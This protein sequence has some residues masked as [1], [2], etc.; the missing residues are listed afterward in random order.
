LWP[1]ALNAQ[2]C[3]NNGFIDL[4]NSL[5][6]TASDLSNPAGCTIGVNCNSDAK[7]QLRATAVSQF[8]ACQTLLVPNGCGQTDYGQDFFPK[9][10]AR[11]ASGDMTLQNEAIA[12]LANLQRTDFGAMGTDA[13]S[14][15]TS[16]GGQLLNSLL[17]ILTNANRRGDGDVTMIGLTT[18]LYAYGKR[19]KNI[20]PQDVYTHVLGL[21]DQTGPGSVDTLSFGGNTVPICAAVCAASV[22]LPVCLSCVAVVEAE[23][24]SI[25]ETENHRNMIYASQYL[26][27]QLRL[28]ETGDPQFDNS[29]NG[30]RPWM[31]NRLNDFVRNDFIEYNS[32]D[33]QDYT[34]V[35]L[36]SLASYADDTAVRTAAKNALDY[37]SAKV[38][39]SNNDARRSTPFRRHNDP[40]NFLCDEL[41]L[42]HCEDPQTSFYMMLAGAWDILENNST[43]DWTVNNVDPRNLVNNLLPP[44]NAA[45]PNYRY[46]FQ[47][48]ATTN[49][50]IDPVILDLFVNPNDRNF[51]Q[52]FHYS[53]SL[54]TD[55]FQDSND[56]LYAGSPSYLISAGGHGTHNAYTADVPFPISVVRGS[57]PGE[58][59]DLGVPVATTL[60]PTAAAPPLSSPPALH[61]RAQMIRFSNPSENMCVAPNF[62]CGALV[63]PA[64]PANYTVSSVVTAPPATGT[65]S[66]IDQHAAKVQFGYYVAFYQQDGF[67]FFE[68]YDTFSNP[69]NVTDLAD[70]QQRVLTNNTGQT[71]S[72]SSGSVNT[73]KTVDGSVIQFTV[74]AHIVAING[75][76]PY[77]PTRTNGTIINSN[78]QGIV[79]ITNPALNQSLTLDATTPPDHPVISVPGPLNFPDTCIGAISSATLDVCNVNTGTADLLVYNILSQNTQ[80]QVAQ[81]SS[82]YPTTVSPDFCF[83]FQ[84]QFTPT[85]VGLTSSK[86]KISS[87]D[88]SVPFLSV[89]V[90]GKGIQQS[91]AAVISNNGNFGNVCAGSFADLNLTIN[92]TGGCTLAISNITSSSSKFTVAGTVSFPLA[93]APG[94][95]LSVPI[96]FQ[97]PAYGSPNY[98]TCS[99]TVPLTASIVIHS[100]DP[101][102]PDPTGFVTQVSGIEGC[103]TLVLSPQNLAGP[104]AFPATVSDLNGTLGCYTDRQILATNSGICP[105]TIA[106]MTTANGLDG[107]GVPLAATP[108][109]FKVVNPTTPITIAPGGAPVPITVR[110]KPT[111][112]TDQNPFAP[113]QQTGQLTITSNDPVAADNAAGLCGEP[114]Y[115]SGARVLVVDS[116]NNPVSSVASL[117]LSSKGLTPPFN[118][119]LKPAPLMTAA[120]I[121]GNTILYQLDNEVLRPAGTTGNNPNSSYSLSAKNG[122]THADMS[123]TLGQCQVQ[124][125]VLQIK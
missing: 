11:L 108:L 116:N 89:A 106:S 75:K 23:Q 61:S 90:T 33:Y 26:A 45:P 58:D 41:L 118:E 53:R 10:F 8:N 57:H 29:R 105:L 88:P 97:P 6:T 55:G 28:D 37:I 93:V 121:C 15:P 125:I 63:S 83:P 103:P 98:V 104:F 112:L 91:I 120:N 81:P 64:I 44:N 119:T 107:K 73:Y 111:I 32:H 3:G 4:S 101:K 36:L 67:G 22:S 7:F 102:Y 40:G 46:A 24:V 78:G 80:F 82:G 47:W 70:F 38:A 43:Q 117:A 92:N 94:G 87:S 21:I 72:G 35:A 66:F 12:A 77:D 30:Y 51:Y 99:N 1:Q 68:V 20:L 123:F 39:V 34:M 110:F 18:V 13:S 59:D 9:V 100:S 96:R 5:P 69:L 56:E 124:Q 27:N 49:Y 17:N 109:E 74:D 86:L 85:L 42:Q 48:A 19:G 114:T 52:F 115:Q 95:S 50:R 79:T 62:A 60:M 2:V 14:C 122:F 71:F 65:W 25:P 54:E 84:A 113:D 16:L 76:P 31:L